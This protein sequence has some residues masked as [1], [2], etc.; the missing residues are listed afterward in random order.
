MFSFIIFATKINIFCYNNKH[1]LYIRCIFNYFLFF[2]R[3]FELPN[4]IDNT[5]DI[6]A[7]N[8]KAHFEFDD[9]IH[10]A[11]KLQILFEKIESQDETDLE[12]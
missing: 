8:S 10:I 11:L 2:D 12:K 4:S 1:I 3:D 5:E 6:T 9:F 7:D